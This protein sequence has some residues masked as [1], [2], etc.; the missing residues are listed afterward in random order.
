M[1]S[2]PDSTLRRIIAVDGVLGAVY[3]VEAAGEGNSLKSAIVA[4]LA[5]LGGSSSH[6]LTARDVRVLRG[7]PPH[8]YFFYTRPVFRTPDPWGPAGPPSVRQRAPVRLIVG[9]THADVV[10]A[11]PNVRNNGFFG[12]F[13]T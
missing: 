9:V 2:Q 10:S 1:D 5:D 13:A 8:T 4:A 12:P 11:P 3:E 7:V 6:L